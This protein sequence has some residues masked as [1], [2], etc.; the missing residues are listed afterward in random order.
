MTDRTLTIPTVTDQ[1][2]SQDQ[3]LQF[4]KPALLA[5]SVPDGALVSFPG[6]LV[7]REAMQ[8]G[9]DCDTWSSSGFSV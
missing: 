2:I 4:P 9:L 7:P 6:V 3:T 8:R 1:V 5:A